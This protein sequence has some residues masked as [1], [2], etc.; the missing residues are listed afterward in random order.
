MQG[1]LFSVHNFGCFV[2]NNILDLFIMLITKCDICKKEIKKSEQIVLAGTGSSFATNSF[3][4]HCGK[5]V[6]DFLKNRF[7]NKN[8]KSKSKNE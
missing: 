8:R 5:P 3:C 6:L 7:Y 2:K 4:L 1:L